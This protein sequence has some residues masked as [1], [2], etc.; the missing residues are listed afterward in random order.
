VRVATSHGD[1]TDRIGRPANSTPSGAER[2]YAIHTSF[3]GEILA[4]GCGTLPPWGET[5]G[6]G[7]AAEVHFKTK[8]GAREDAVG[9]VPGSFPE[10]YSKSGESFAQNWDPLLGIERELQ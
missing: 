6:L 4:F 8:I 7:A 5:G 3:F 10:D 9:G 1:A 2:G